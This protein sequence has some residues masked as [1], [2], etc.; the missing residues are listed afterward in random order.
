MFRLKFKVKTKQ[1][2]NLIENI[3]KIIM[4][5]KKYLIHKQNK[6]PQLKI[7]LI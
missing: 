7:I 5:L 3:Y 6:Q 2:T 1:F 4:S